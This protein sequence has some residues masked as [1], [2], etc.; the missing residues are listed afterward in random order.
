MKGVDDKDTISGVFHYFNNMDLTGWSSKDMPKTLIK[1]NMILENRPPLITFLQEFVENVHLPHDTFHLKNDSSIWRI[2][3]PTFRKK[4]LK[5]C[6]SSGLSVLGM[7]A[8][9]FNRDILE[10]EPITSIKTRIDGQI[11]QACFS[12]NKTELYNLLES[13]YP[14]E[15]IEVDDSENV[16][17]C[18]ITTD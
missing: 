17:N 12:I 6:E 5:Y 3:K 8:S 13:E 1:Q 18:D 9:K 7:N 11:G 14:Q 2:K 16:G 15:K 4:Y 10:F